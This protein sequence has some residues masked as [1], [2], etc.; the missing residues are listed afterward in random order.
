[1]GACMKL[2]PCLNLPDCHLGHYTLQL[3]LY[4][5]MLIQFG[6]IPGRL[7]LL[8]YDIPDREVKAIVEQGILPDIEPTVHEVAYAE[9]E[10]S[11]VMKERL[12]ELKIQR[13]KQW[14]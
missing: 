5:W 9:K 10:V 7:E 4:A 12:N 2:Y 1:M 8:H 3:S 6:L 13:R 11:L 14:V